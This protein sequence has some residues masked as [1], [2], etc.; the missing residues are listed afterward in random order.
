MSQIDR[1]TCEQ[2]FRRLDDYIDRELSPG[3]MELVRQHL[4]I[5]AVCAMEHRFQA[6][7]IQHV[8]NRLQRI[9]LPAQLLERISLSLEQTI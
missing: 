1:Y 7:V 8:R 9:A 3:E 6:S 2:V 5:C 4:E